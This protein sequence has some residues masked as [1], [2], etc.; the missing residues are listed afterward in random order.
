VE[1]E[2]TPKKAE[3]HLQKPREKTMARCGDQTHHPI[4]W[5][6]PPVTCAAGIHPAMEQQRRK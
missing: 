6:L 5:L 2:T 4:A 1:K 3:D